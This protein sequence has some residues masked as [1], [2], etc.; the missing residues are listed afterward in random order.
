MLNFS[1]LKYPCITWLITSAISIIVSIFKDMLNQYFKITR[2]LLYNPYYKWSE[3]WLF[4]I[5]ILLIICFC[6]FILIWIFK[7]QLKSLIGKEILAIILSF[8]IIPL[9]IPYN[10]LPQYLRN[11]SNFPL[12]GE[13]FF[14]IVEV[15]IG[16][17]FVPIIYSILKGKRNKD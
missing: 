5:V 9:F 6:Y 2:S 10:T 15:G 11:F 13:Y 16:G 1:K 3:F 4:L 7:D 14:D 12:L 17:S 8:F